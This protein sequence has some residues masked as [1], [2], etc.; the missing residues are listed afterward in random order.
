MVK[1][2]VIPGSARRDS[3]NRKLA[4][5]AANI[6]GEWGAQTDVVGP[7]DLDL[8]LFDQDLEDAS[9]LP[10]AARSLKERF[11]EADGLL[12]V[13]PEYNSSITPLMKNI[14]DWVSRSEKEDEPPLSAY[15]GKTAALLA[16]SPGA[17][18]GL[19][20]LVHLRSIL[21][22]IGVVV[23]P[24]QFALA[25]ASGKF[26]EDGTLTDADAVRSVTRVVRELVGTTSKLKA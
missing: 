13:S 19:R 24:T 23:T 16:A 10:A 2:L 17:L 6:A 15:R 3:I 22:N 14:I 9:G 8:P 11:I 21:G 20:G 25:S 26:A 12:F 1:I 5:A 18:G 4:A 7:E